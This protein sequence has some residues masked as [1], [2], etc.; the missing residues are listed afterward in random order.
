MTTL[1]IFRDIAPEFVAMS[2]AQVNRFI[3]Y[4]TPQVSQ[5][6]FGDD[7]GLALAYLAADMIAIAARKGGTAGI[8]SAKREG[9]LSIN[10]AVPT[11]MTYVTTYGQRFSVLMRKHVL[12]VLVGNNIG[13][14]SI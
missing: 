2:D 1:E 9:E 5:S 14:T 11:D 6:Y 3:G 13:A 12:S 4:V 10:Y 7:Y 8:I